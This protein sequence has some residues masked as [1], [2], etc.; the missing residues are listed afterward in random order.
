MKTK[1]KKIIL[2]SLLSL[3]FC[4]LLYFAITPQKLTVYAQSED[5]F[6]E[7]VYEYTDE[8]GGYTVTLISETEYTLHAVRDSDELNF[9]G[10]YTLEGSVLKLFMLGEPLETFEI[11]E[12]NTLVMVD[13]TDE[14]ADELPEETKEGNYFREKIMPYITANISSI[15]T[16]LLTITVTLG[17]LKAATTEL[18]ASNSENGYLKKKNKKLEEDIVELKKEVASIKKDTSNT[19]EIVKIGF[20]NTSELVENGYAEEIAKVGEHEEESQS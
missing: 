12:D 18:K 17:K 1:S 16:A 19:K 14:P 7:K 2:F 20:C 11:Q 5:V 8:G 4:G 15:L 9:K 3:I 10:T 6:I 13:T